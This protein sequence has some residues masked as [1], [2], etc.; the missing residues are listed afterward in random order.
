VTAAMSRFVPCNESKQV[1][2]PANHR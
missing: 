1:A 2:E